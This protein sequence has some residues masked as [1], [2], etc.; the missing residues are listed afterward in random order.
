MMYR[1]TYCEAETG[2]GRMITFMVAFRFD[3]GMAG[4]RGGCGIAS[5]PWTVS[6]VGL[7]SI[8]QGVSAA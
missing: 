4:E 1:A 5:L 6:G 7:A 2:S 8:Y 3:E